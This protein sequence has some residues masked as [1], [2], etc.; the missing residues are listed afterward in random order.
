MSSSQI[1]VVMY[2]Y[3]RPL[4]STYYPDIKGLDYAGFRRQVAYLKEH[5]EPLTLKDCTDALYNNAALPE[6][7]VLMTFDDGYTD[8]FNYAMPILDEFNM[9]GVF[10][11]PLNAIR[12]R[13]ILDVNK[14]HYILAATKDIAGITDF[15][16]KGLD[17][18]RND[19]ELKS[20]EEYFASVAVPTRYDSKE[21]VF[22]KKMLQRELPFELRQKITS[23][24]FQKYVTKD[25]AGFAESLYMNED[26]LKYMVR[27]GFR[28]GG[29]TVTHQWLNKQT[30]AEQE[31]EISHSKKLLLDIG[32]SQTELSFAYPYGGYN[33]DT[34]KI[35]NAQGF[36]I[37]FT[38]EVGKATVSHDNRF[39]LSRLN[40]NDFPS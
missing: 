29:H 16:F 3:V 34:L 20:N 25:E 7:G 37:G 33:E 9:S 38:T 31:F 19:H 13:E 12:E 22:I 15:I 8:H 30:I 27:N 1:T 24:L 23:Q 28:V 40:T 6:N 21:V 4:A 11:A 18:Y 14:I 26:Q 32:V 2:H 39:T 10:F 17:G 36:K 35:M 5:F